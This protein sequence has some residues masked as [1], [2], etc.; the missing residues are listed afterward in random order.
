MERHG[1]AFWEEQLRD[2]WGSGFTVSEYSELIGQPRLN[3]QR[4]IRKLS[5][6]QESA[7]IEDS[8]SGQTESSPQSCSIRM[9]EVV[10]KEIE[11]RKED[12]SQASGVR[13]RIGDLEIDLARGFDREVLESVL[14]M[15]RFKDILHDFAAQRNLGY[16]YLK[17]KGVKKDKA[18]ARKWLEKAAAQSDSYAQELLAESFPDSE[19]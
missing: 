19:K 8:D 16:L 2:Y 6:E 1:R 4:W 11:E 3:V 15:L 12:C 17:G 10:P 13:L 14:A 9:I 5:S 7:G 18:E